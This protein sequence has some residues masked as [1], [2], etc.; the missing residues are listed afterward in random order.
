M[1]TDPLATHLYWF[2]RMT[3]RNYASSVVNDLIQ[4]EVSC[5][6]TVTAPQTEKMAKSVRMCL[7]EEIVESLTLSSVQKSCRD[8]KEK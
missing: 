3:F 8:P 5:M 2:Y 1:T 7:P 4:T 6:K